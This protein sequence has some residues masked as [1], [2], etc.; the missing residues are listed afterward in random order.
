MSNMFELEQA[1][2]NMW[3]IVEDIEILASQNADQN[4]FNSLAK[5]YQ[6]KFTHLFDIYEQHVAEVHKAKELL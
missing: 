2:L 4:A 3:N 5:V 6:Y 1:I